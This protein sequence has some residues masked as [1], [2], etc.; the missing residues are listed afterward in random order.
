MQLFGGFGCY[1]RVG[2]W[3]HSIAWVFFETVNP[4]NTWVSGGPDGNDIVLDL[5]RQVVQQIGISSWHRVRFPGAWVLLWVI[6]SQTRQ[7]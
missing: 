1:A 3:V 5:K 2:R 7:G 4:G 6:T